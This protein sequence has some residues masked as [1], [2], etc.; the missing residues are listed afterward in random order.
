MML[1]NEHEREVK[2]ECGRGTEGEHKGGSGR[3]TYL[4]IGEILLKEIVTEELSAQSSNSNKSL[5]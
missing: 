1:E 3:C 4:L 2:D 5:C